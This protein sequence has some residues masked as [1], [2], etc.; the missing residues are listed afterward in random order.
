[1]E[2]TIKPVVMGPEKPAVV[3][4]EQA[5][6]ALG[7]FMTALYS[8]TGDAATALQ[9]VDKIS[10]GIEADPELSRNVFTPENI[11]KVMHLQRKAQ[12]GKVTLDD[13]MNAFPVIGQMVPAPLLAMFKNFMK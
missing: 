2:T 4:R 7:R 1:M 11:E 3:T 8:A 12:T 6:Q 13:L 5:E 9:V 10:E